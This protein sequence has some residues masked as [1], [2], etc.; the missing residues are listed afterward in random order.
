MK[1]VGDSSAVF[2]TRRWMRTAVLR[3][4]AVLLAAAFAAATLTMVAVASLAV[5]PDQQREME[6]GAFTRTTFSEVQ[7]GDVDPGFLTQV[8]RQ[9]SERVGGEVHLAIQSTLLRPDSFEKS[10]IQGPIAPV[11]FVQDGELSKAFPDRYSIDGGGGRWPSRPFDVV[12]SAQLRDKLP[13]PSRFTVMSGR[14]TFRVV[15]VVE[16][17]YD[18]RGDLIVAA[19]GTWESIQAPDPRRVY[20][21]VSASVQVWWTD[22]SDAEVVN[23]VN[24]VMPPLPR[25]LGNRLDY[26]RDNTTTRAEV[27]PDGRRGPF[28]TGDL[29]ASYL[30]L[31]MVIV[32]ASAVS[33][34]LPRWQQR[35]VANT[36]T[37]IGV[38]RRLVIRTQ[39]VAAA[40]VAAVSAAIGVGVGLVGAIGLR[41]TVLPEVA[42][43]QLSPLSV[44][45]GTIAGLFVLCELL[46]LAGTTALA[47]SR[48]TPG[49]Q[50][51][52]NRPARAWPRRA[53]IVA[54]VVWALLVADQKKVQTAYLVGAAAVLIAPDVLR[55]AIRIWGQRSPLAFVTARLMRSDLPRLAVSAV[56]TAACVAIPICIGT[57]LS[58]KI[59]SDASFT[60]GYVP[61]GQMWVENNGGPG[62]VAAVAA[63]V[64]RAPGVPAP[65][66]MWELRSGPADRSS[67]AFFTNEPDQGE[68]TNGTIMVIQSPGDLDRLLPGQLPDEAEA[69]LDGGGVLDFTGAGGA[70]QFVVVGADGSQRLTPTITTMKVPVNRQY[71]TSFGGVI[72]RSTAERLDLPITSGPTK[73]L[74]ADVSSGS[75]SA[76]VDAV[77]AGGYDSEFVLYAVTPPPPDLPTSGYVFLACLITAV[78][79]LQLTVVRHQADRLR[80]YSTRLV[81]LGVT[82]RW[83][84]SLLLRQSATLVLVGVLVGLTAGVLGVVVA[85]AN[86]AVVDIPVLPVTLAIIGVVALSAIAT[87]SASHR[88]NPRRP[89]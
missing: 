48:A 89:R 54:V 11:R 13:D 56:M 39:A 83:I 24:A 80:S 76:A 47:L 77:V 84:R 87:I 82:P 40:T 38:R 74:Y 61:P 59:A 78:V 63:I 64:S 43:Q 58:S 15:G 46:V 67:N 2:L 12:V 7:V 37:R 42:D 34:A 8:Q 66:P 72:L 22:P 73:Y 10:F 53:V 85:S 19:P 52:R 5:T 70:Q 30:P 69:V 31:V 17:A 26:L 9:V 36:L 71:T 25:S 49:S 32:L 62:D 79:V 16:D 68:F 4:S 57:Q 23:A 27:T 45:W 14:A 88:L 60:Y 51:P 29:V 86:F 33:V 28:G 50:H 55:L 18:K 35:A 75:I 6:F 81:A 41:S 21:P 44:P 1:R 65:M 20:E 3:R